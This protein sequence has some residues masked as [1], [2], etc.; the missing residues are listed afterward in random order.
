MRKPNESNPQLPFREGHSFNRF[1]VAPQDPFKRNKRESEVPQV[2]QRQMV[3]P[4]NS[5][6]MIAPASCLKLVKDQKGK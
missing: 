4:L 1:G 3:M 6:E 5:I 2:L